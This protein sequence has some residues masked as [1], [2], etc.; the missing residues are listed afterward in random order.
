MERDVSDLEIKQLKSERQ[1][2]KTKQRVEGKQRE[3]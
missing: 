1:G 3:K 2:D